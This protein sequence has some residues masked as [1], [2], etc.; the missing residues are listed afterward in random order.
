MRPQGRAGEAILPVIP[1]DPEEEAQ[2]YRESGTR[3]RRLDL[4]FI[5]FAGPLTQAERLRLFR[6]LG[7]VPPVQ[8][9]MVEC[10]EG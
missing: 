1:E 6:E 10:P 7:R 9:V 4:L 5:A 3:A 2:V 8:F